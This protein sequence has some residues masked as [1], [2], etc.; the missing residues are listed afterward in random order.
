MSATLINPKL[1]KMVRDLYRADLLER[2]I[3]TMLDLAA[4]IIQE[5]IDNCSVER[6]AEVRRQAAEEAWD[7]AMTFIYANAWVDLDPGKVPIE[8]P[9]RKE[10]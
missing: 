10:Q 5:H 4:D 8:N 7:Q 2:S 6:L 3:Q 9:Y 1:P